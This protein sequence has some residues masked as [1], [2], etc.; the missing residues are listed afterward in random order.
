MSSSLSLVSSPVAESRVDPLRSR[1]RVITVAWLYGAFWLSTV[2]GAALAKF[3]IEMGTPQWAYGILSALP[4][5]GCLCQL[6][7]VFLQPRLGH[8]KEV[9]IVSVLIGRLMW[10]VAAAVPWVLPHAREWWWPLMTAAFLLGWAG[11]NA[12]SPAWM[13]WMA[14]V[15]PK[16]L[17]GRYFAV[18]SRLGQF[19]S[20]A[21]TLGIG[22]LLNL[23]DGDGSP[24]LML[25]VCSGV[26]AIAGLMG[27]LDILMFRRVPDQFRP[28]TND[29]PGAWESMKEVFADKNYMRYMGFVFTLYLAIGFIQQY[30]WL[31]MLGEIHYSPWRANLLLIA[32]PVLVQA[33][34]YGAWGRLIDRLGRKPALLIAGVFVVNGAWGWLLV[35]HGGWPFELF[36]YECSGL[37]IIGYAV[38]V[39]AMVAWPGAELAMLNV[40]MGMAGTRDGR[41]NGNAYVAVNYLALAAGGILSGFLGG[42]VAGALENLRWMIPLLGIPLTYHGVL[43]ILSAGLRGAALLFIVAM[44]EPRAA[45]TRDAMRYVTFNLYS[46]AVEVMTN[47]PGRIVSHAAK[48]GFRLNPRK[49]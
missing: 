44:T 20:M 33:C 22:V 36:G 37:S 38:A 12:G 29:Q 10:V 5:L 46:N 48:V 16:R 47:L 11:N 27:A 32:V 8:R 19:V 35:G 18:R 23:V 31:Y 9:F 28:D 2:N 49:S 24:G 30:I 3:Q 14:D 4:Y 43:F 40:V 45:R 26:L 41:R 39:S 21:A 7:M 34:M 25:K 6:P 15:I 17:R 13:D 42:F 1:L